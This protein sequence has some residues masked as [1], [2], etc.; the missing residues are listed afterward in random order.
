M[1]FIINGGISS[2][3]AGRVILSAILLILLSSC[4]RP[5]KVDVQ[6]R[7]QAIKLCLER[8]E[9][10][11]KEDLARDKFSLLRSNEYDNVEILDSY[12]KP[13]RNDKFKNYWYAAGWVEYL[14]RPTE[15]YRD[16]SSNELK[17]VMFVLPISWREQRKE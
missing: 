12:C 14:K 13:T 5:P 6:G 16:V 10:K 8:L 7:D 9:R 17:K 3:M 1:Y 15:K 11:I 4:Q 2:V